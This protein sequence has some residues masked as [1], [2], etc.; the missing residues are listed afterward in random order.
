[1][2]IVARKVPT[3]LVTTFNTQKREYKVNQNH[4]SRKLVSIKPVSIKPVSIKLVS[5]KPVSIKPVSIKPV[6][7]KLVSIKPVSI[8]PV[9]LKPV[10]K[11]SFLV[12]FLS[13]FS[14]L[15][16]RSLKFSW[17]CPRM[18]TPI[19]PSSTLSWKP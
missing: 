15:R 4:P 9:S 8:K 17:F 11:V 13:L 6:S 2:Q 10:F 18:L 16:V 12:L 5:I 19:K 1:M 3:L 7:I 14:L